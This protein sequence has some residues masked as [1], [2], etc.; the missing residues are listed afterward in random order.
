[1]VNFKLNN[2]FFQHSE[3]NQNN[4]CPWASL[5]PRK[6]IR[7]TVVTKFGLDPIIRLDEVFF[8]SEGA[9]LKFRP[10]LCRNVIFK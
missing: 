3:K 7:Q 2:I 4:F 10:V 1:M 9:K 8:L 6:M 5:N